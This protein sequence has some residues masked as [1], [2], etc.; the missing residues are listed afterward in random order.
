M[1]EA[2]TGISPD[3]GFIALDDVMVRDGACSALKGTCDF[4]NDDLCDWLNM[5]DSELSWLLN[6]RQVF[7]N[8]TW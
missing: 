4:E 8:G 6:Q 5:P 3:Q 1:F 7:K 2:V